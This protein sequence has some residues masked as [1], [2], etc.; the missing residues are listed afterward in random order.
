MENGSQSV[1]QLLGHSRVRMAVLAVLVLLGAF[2]AA[3]TVNSVKEFQY[4]GASPT[5]NAITVNGKGEVFAVPD[6][7]SFTFSVIEEAPSAA[8]AQDE[9]ARKAQ[10][11]TAFIK[12]QGIEE[13]DIKT[14]SF[15]LYPRYEFRQ[16]G[17]SS[18][19]YPPSG[20][21]QLVGF[22][23]NQTVEVKVRD[24]A[25]AG[26]LIAGAAELGAGSV[27]SLLFTVDDIEKLKD[28]A[29][30]MAIRDAKAR[31]EVLADGLDI[32]LGRVIS[33]GEYEE[34]IYYGR[35]GGLGGAEA[36][37][38]ASADAV[39]SGGE[40]RIISSVTVTYEIR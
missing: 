13:K 14:I 4:I 25:K 9:A 26:K 23:I 29:R 24:T 3:A 15:E 21:R 30:E 6:V 11:I 17:A 7:A 10:S 36:Y 38:V 31:A 8:A 12:E 18:L 2:L 28:E 37:S 22:E 34:P 35:S 5:Y 27:G 16:T 32:R 39:V 40:N 20:D 1:M 33:Y 19:I